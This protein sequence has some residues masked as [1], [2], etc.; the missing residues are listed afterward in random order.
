MLKFE[1]G[2]R[3][4][5]YCA[6]AAFVA[7]MCAACSEDSNGSDN[8]T[9][10]SMAGA[11]GSTLQG[12]GGTIGIGSGGTVGGGVSG[13]G[14]KSGTFGRLDTGTSSGSGGAAPK[15]SA[16]GTGGAGGSSSG[17]SS[18][19]GT[20][21]NGNGGSDTGSGNPG[22]DIV[23]AGVRWIGRVDLSD[24]MKPRFSWSGAGFAARFQGTSLT[25]QLNNSG[26]FIFKAVID[27]TPQAPFTSASGQSTYTLASNLAAGDHAVELYRQT[28]GPQGDSRFVSISAPNGVL[29]TPPPGPG[30]LIEVVGDSI[31]CG[32]GTLGS[33]SDSDCFKTE[34]HWDTYEG[35]AARQVGAELSTVCASG[36]GIVRNYDG[37]TTDTL[38]AVYDRA[39]ANSATPKWGFG[40]QP[41]AVVINLG[42]N[43]ANG[44]NG[45]PGTAF[46]TAYLAFVENI[47]SKYPNAFIVC[48]IGPML[49]G[50]KLTIIQNY[51]KAVVSKR[52]AAGDNKISFFDKI[53][54][55]TEDKFACQYHPNV[56]ENK[57]M[58]DQLAAEL[59]TKLGW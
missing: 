9:S 35:L 6:F 39:V 17:T 1:R 46:E 56:A 45:D 21:A 5:V 7:T 52:N 36:R 23:S 28:E 13:S 32:Y 58:G 59:E 10:G 3:G 8:G 2:K 19:G 57:L 18:G 24:E 47:R 37:S 38:P 53:A 49:S 48:M 33:L 22:G 14:G 42:T 4:I 54:V 16:G 12:T 15:A 11:E 31:S 40:P 44:S 25:V 51:I 30:R 20:V 26:A 43:D 34:T 41:Q 27:G 50:D 29:L 55:Q